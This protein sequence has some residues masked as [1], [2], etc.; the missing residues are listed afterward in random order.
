MLRNMVAVLAAIGLV[1]AL[2]AAL[3]VQGQ[4]SP[5]PYPR[6][7]KPVESVIVYSDSTESAAS[8]HNVIYLLLTNVQF[9]TGNFF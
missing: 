4:Q 9:K 6:S 8:L 2:A 5:F 3:P 1:F 7:T